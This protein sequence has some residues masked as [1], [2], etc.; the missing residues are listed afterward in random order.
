MT[1]KNILLIS[2]LFLSIVVKTQTVS[3]VY[4][5]DQLMNRVANPDTTYILNFWATW[6]K[7]CVQ[8][9]PSF[10]SLEATI[11][12]TPA[13]IILVCLDF[14]EELDKKVAPFLIKHKI[15]IECVLLDE[16]NGN[17]FINKVDSK[18]TGAIPATLFKKN[19]YK[20][21]VEKKM[22]LSE[23]EKHLVDVERK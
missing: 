17:D 11:K 23:L 6:C 10:D 8:E 15:K 19:S 14:K 1:I 9:L 22:H 3:H 4:K 18:W 16:V 7:P 13:K 20:N 2:L 21:L 12:K 5:I